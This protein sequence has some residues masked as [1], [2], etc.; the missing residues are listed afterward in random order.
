VLGQ[1]LA[2]VSYMGQRRAKDGSPAQT[3]AFA[4]LLRKTDAGWKIVTITFFP[5]TDFVTLD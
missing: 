5:A 4:Y 2:L 3:L 1:S